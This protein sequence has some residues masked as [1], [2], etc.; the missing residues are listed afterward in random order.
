[1]CAGITPAIRFPAFHA[2]RAAPGS[3]FEDF[4]PVIWRMQLQELPV[5]GQLRAAAVFDT[6][7][8]VG[9][10]HIAIMMMVTVTLAVRCDMRELRPGALVG[11]AAQQAIRKSFAV[12]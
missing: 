9:Q 7:Q 1:M 6:M 5:I 10:R 8:G 12:A 11:K 4:N 2:V 3:I